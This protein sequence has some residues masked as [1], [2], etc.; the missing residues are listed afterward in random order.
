MVL[1]MKIKFL[2]S[3]AIGLLALKTAAQSPDSYTDSLLVVA[4]QKANA[5]NYAEALHLQALAETVILESVG[6]SSPLYGRAVLTKARIVHNQKQYATA[7]SLYQAALK[8]LDLPAPDEHYAQALFSLGAL[9]IDMGNYA[10]AEG[11]LRQSLSLREQL[12]GKQHI[13]YV[14]TLTN[15]GLSESET[16][17]YDSAVVH[18]KE[19]VSYWQQAKVSPSSEYAKAINN[20]A[21]TYMRMGE[22]D[23]AQ[24]LLVSAC[25]IRRVV[26]GEKHPDYASSLN[27][28]ANLYANKGMYE[29]SIPLCTQAKDIRYQTLGPTHPRYA[30]SVNNLANLYLSL[31]RFE[32]AEPL[33]L[34]ALKI[35]EQVTGK[36]HADYAMSLTN[37]GNLYAQT[38]NYERA[39]SLLKEAA[40][41][42]HR[43]LGS[44]HPDY[45][46]A[47]EN[48]ANLYRSTGQLEQAGRLL[49]QALTAQ[50]GRVNASHPEYVTTLLNL[51]NVYIEQA[52]PGLAKPV[53]D[54]CMVRF[55]QNP[56]KKHPFYA[57]TLRS[58][59]RLSMNAGDWD[60]ALQYVSEG[61]EILRRSVGIFHPDFLAM[62]DLLGE[63]FLDQGNW[64]AG[65]AMIDSSGLISRQMLVNSARHFSEKELQAYLKTFSRQL[66]VNGQL[67]EQYPP[68]VG[69]CFDN[70]LFF[71]GF[72]QNSVL[73]I[74]Q[75][76]ARFAPAAPVYDELKGVQRL[77][78]DAL[79]QPVEQQQQVASLRQKANDLEKE[80]IR[81]VA[82]WGD[83]MHQVTWQEVQSKLQSGE[84]V[85][86]FFRYTP[87]AQS[88]NAP[89]RYAALLLKP[90]NNIPLFIP[91]CDELTL[92]K[93]LGKGKRSRPDAI[94]AMYK[95]KSDAASL[96]QLLWRPLEKNLSEEHTLYCAPDGLLHRVAFDAIGLPDGKTVFDRFR[97]VLLGSSR[98]LAVAPAAEA[99][100]TKKAWLFGGIRYDMDTLEMEKSLREAVL[101]SHENRGTPLW[102]DPPTPSEWPFLKWT[103]V[104]VQTAD[105]TL[106]DAGLEPRVFSGF[107]A[108]EEAFKSAELS[109]PFLIHV[110]THGFFF[111]P[112]TVYPVNNNAGAGRWMRADVP[113]M[114]S[115]LVMAGANY[116]W[117]HG[118]PARPGWSDGILTAQ[119]ISQMYLPGTQLAVLSACDTGLGDIEGSEGVYGLQRAFRIA[120]VRYVMMSLWPAP[121]FQTQEFM[122]L[123][124]SAWLD[125]GRTVP[126]AFSTAQRQM[127]QRYNDPFFWAGFV[128]LQ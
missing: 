83:A 101:A 15:L 28:L 87:V 29:A 86:E 33:L 1:R 109:V 53:L 64:P 49:K 106:K 72:L 76:A 58:M 2:L 120:G 81:S 100:L 56:G 46:G 12:L 16:G 59:G 57:Q 128:L 96:Y 8:L 45:A 110:A 25:D 90:E 35:K 66:S 20:L 78:S 62:T 68:S 111:E 19:V 116:A 17:H 63:I 61:R 84:A 18:Q 107:A 31:G 74:R 82:G 108:T 3:V 23:T 11:L 105:L 50:G 104:E 113:M 88:A 115:G 71:K 43:V 30:W 117:Q 95:Y 51:A 70:L 32:A 73:Q 47:L 39:E 123:F 55:A 24:P 6:S 125:E 38:G 5:K 79:S 121:D 60:A 75:S 124:Y 14:Y 4:I 54:T 34:E 89:A 126:D 13:E 97:V 114:R 26:L 44:T 119:E 77:L 69:I 48:L 127:K 102:T 36:E 112:D 40:D 21:L 91:L 37:L 122:T 99:P 9:Y 27:N 98:Q 118:V 92:Q 65:M 42:R 85:V 7:D 94:R 67:A 80:L 41:I 103:A 22:Y 52:Y 93:V 10:P